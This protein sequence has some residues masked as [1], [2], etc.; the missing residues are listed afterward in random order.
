ML[1]PGCDMPDERCECAPV[2]MPQAPALERE[3]LRFAY[4]NT[5]NETMERRVVS[6]ILRFDARLRRW[7]VDGYDLDRRDR[8]TFDFDKMRPSE[9]V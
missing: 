6:P 7:V 4:T 3:P 8:R 5:R 1:C 9:V 2:S